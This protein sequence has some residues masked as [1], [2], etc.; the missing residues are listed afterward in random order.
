MGVAAAT[1][2]R[3]VWRAS[4]SDCSWSGAGAVR[5]HEREYRDRRDE[6]EARRHHEG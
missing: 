1:L 6:A 3:W 2:Y 5:R 4:A